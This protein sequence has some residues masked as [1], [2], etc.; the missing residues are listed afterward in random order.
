MSDSIHPTQISTNLMVSFQHENSFRC[1]IHADSAT[2]P[3][4]VWL[5]PK[6]IIRLLRHGAELREAGGDAA[7]HVGEAHLEGPLLSGA[8]DGGF[9]STN[10]RLRIRDDT[11]SGNIPW[12]AI[13]TRIL[14]LL[15]KAS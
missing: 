6:K 4:D 9:V 11:P 13:K 2:Q 3:R 8:L 10:Q 7:H 12:V 14:N 5:A 15:S 1:A